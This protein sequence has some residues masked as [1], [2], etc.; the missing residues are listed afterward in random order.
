M[1]I[2][3][4]RDAGVARWLER[5]DDRGIREGGSGR[6]RKERGE[7]AILLIYVPFHVICIYTTVSLA[8]QNDPMSI[9]FLYIYLNSHQ[10]SIKN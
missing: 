10:S 6:G 5:R 1:N 4:E 7:A 8:A 2:D 9:S 3:C